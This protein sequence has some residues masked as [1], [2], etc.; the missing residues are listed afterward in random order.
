MAE[1]K[2][3]A[4]LTPTTPLADAARWALAVRLEVVRDFLRLALHEAGGDDSGDD[5]GVADGQDQLGSAHPFAPTG[6]R[7]NRR[8][9]AAGAARRKGKGERRKGRG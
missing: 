8:D 3:I 2:W 4:E 5:R 9:R 6:G 1:G 7:D